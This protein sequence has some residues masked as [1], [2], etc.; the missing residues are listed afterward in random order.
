MTRKLVLSLALIAVVVT[1]CGSKDVLVKPTA[2]VGASDMPPTDGSAAPNNNVNASAAKAYRDALTKSLAAAK[3]DGLTEVWTD[4]GN[5]PS[6]VLSWNGSTKKGVQQ[7]LTDDSAEA[8]DFDAMMP[9]ANIDELDSIEQNLDQG[10]VEM[11]SATVFIVT[12]IM[13]ESKFVTTYTLDSQ[14]RLGKAASTIDGDP[15][16][17]ATFDYSVTSAGAKAF[18]ALK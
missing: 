13:D 14:G 18:K 2:S 10:T 5:A 17:N 4:E 16:G 15:A 9:Q 1:G 3:S 8:I 12:T 6:T 11:K 7:D